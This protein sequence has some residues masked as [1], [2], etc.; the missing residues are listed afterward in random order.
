MESGHIF[1]KKRTEKTLNR[2][3]S[4]VV[5]AINQLWCSDSGSKAG[6]PYKMNMPFMCTNKKTNYYD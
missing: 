5:P 1:S 4:L 6:T 3:N 2:E